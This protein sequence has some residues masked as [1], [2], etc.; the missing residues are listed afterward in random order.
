MDYCELKNS[1]IKGVYKDTMLI[2]RQ[3]ALGDIARILQSVTEKAMDEL[4]IGYYFLK[5]KNL[6]WVICLLAS[7]GCRKKVRLWKSIL[8]QGRIDLECILGDMPCFLP[9]ANA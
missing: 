9:K 5:A 4:G 1:D 6:I 7:K 3:Y 2:A 8:G